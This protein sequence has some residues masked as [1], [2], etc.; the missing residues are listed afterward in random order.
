MIKIRKYYS[1]GI[2]TVVYNIQDVGFLPLERDGLVPVDMEMR[3]I[4]IRRR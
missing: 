3:R 1:S 4:A 2:T